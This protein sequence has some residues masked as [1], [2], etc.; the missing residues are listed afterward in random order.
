[1]V[2]VRAELVALREDKRPDPEL[3]L[4]RRT[5]VQGS[6]VEG[7]ADGNLTGS[8]YLV[9]RAGCDMDEPPPSTPLRRHRALLVDVTTEEDVNPALQPA[10]DLRTISEPARWVVRQCDD[11][12]ICARALEG[13]A[14]LAQSQPK[15][16][17][18]LVVVGQQRR[19]QPHQAQS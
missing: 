5:G 4:P 3:E 16:S 10:L 19:V 8:S 17:L 6:E 1:V 15:M 13:P 12:L 14:E 7:E 11:E 9:E 2:R 18:V